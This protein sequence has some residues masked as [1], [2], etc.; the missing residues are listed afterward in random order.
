MSLRYKTV[1][2][3]GLALS[4][5]FGVYRRFYRNTPFSESDSA[6]PT[7][8]QDSAGKNPVNPANTTITGVTVSS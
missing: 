4:L 3:V 5:F 2:A 8:D 1:F 7:L 6:G